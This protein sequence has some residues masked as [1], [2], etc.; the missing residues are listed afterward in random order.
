M[1]AEIHGFH[2]EDYYLAQ[3]AFMIWKVK[4]PKSR[5]HTLEDFIIKFKKASEERSPEKPAI[6]PEERVKR[7]KVAWLSGIL[8]PKGA[9]L[10]TRTPPKK[11]KR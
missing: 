4:H 11:K 5:A 3:I 7:S 10:V 8:G 2:R 6:P 1:D 9:K